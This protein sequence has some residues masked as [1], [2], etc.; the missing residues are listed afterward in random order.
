MSLLSW[1]SKRNSQFRKTE[2]MLLALSRSI[3]NFIVQDLHFL[4]RIFKAFLLTDFLAFKTP[5]ST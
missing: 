5:E 4:L 1:C 2:L 3:L